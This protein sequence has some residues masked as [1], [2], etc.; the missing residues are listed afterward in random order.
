MRDSK[1]S[2]W[3]YSVLPYQIAYSPISTIIALFI[4]QLHGTVIDVSYAMAAFYGISI[5]AA[6]FWGWLIDTYN[7]RKSFVILSF[8]GV[9]IVLLGLS[10]TNSVA[11]AI[12]LFGVLS[13]LVA[14]NATPLSLLVMESIEER[15]WSA[16]FS[17]LQLLGSVGGTIGLFLA[18]VL[19]FLPLRLLMLLLIPFSI[20]AVSI[21]TRIREPQAEMGRRAIIKNR[22]ALKVRFLMYHLFFIRIP[23]K[24]F[25]RSLVIRRGSGKSLPNLTVLYIAFFAFY[26]GSGIFNTAYVP[27]LD[28]E[29]FQN[30]YVFGIIFAGYA[31]QSLSFYLYG[32]LTQQSGEHKAIMNS[33]VLRGGGYVAIGLVFLV[34]SGMTSL[35]LN[36]IVY[37]MT[38]GLAYAVFYIASSTVLFE[39]IGTE[40]RGRKLGLYSSIIG[41]SYLFGSLFAGYASYYIGY[42]FSFVISGVLIFGSMIVFVKFYDNEKKL[43]FSQILQLGYVK[44]QS[45]Q[46]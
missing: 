13:F 9:A 39:T 7:G 44:G 42:G 37:S 2:F 17:R 34:F 11:E 12:I 8:L 32:R 36:L 16:G 4:L 43:P 41:L 6:V 46:Q 31:V 15:S 3:M 23:D 38:A 10:L 25:L 30:L 45:S 29:G 22:V 19:G 24:K 40:K 21:A 1:G 33:L 28:H 5:P 20:F 26:L 35:A 14:A 18:T 27:G